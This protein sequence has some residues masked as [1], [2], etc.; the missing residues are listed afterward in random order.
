MAHISV[1]S[2]IFLQ[3]TQLTWFDSTTGRISAL[4]LTE[5]YIR[6]MEVVNPEQFMSLIEKHLGEPTTPQLTSLVLDQSLIFKKSIPTTASSADDIEAFLNIVPFE[7]VAQTQVSTQTETLVMATNQMIITCV[8]R[9]LRK[10]GD[11]LAV[12]LPQTVFDM[13]QQQL[14]PLTLESATLMLTQSPGLEAYNLTLPEHP[15]VVES[16]PTESSA[17]TTTIE[18]PSYAPDEPKKQST[19]KYLVPLF[20]LLVI[21]LVGLIVWQRQPPSRPTSTLV[22]AAT[23]NTTTATKNPQSQTMQI[24]A[25]QVS[26]QVLSPQT[27]LARAEEVTKTFSEAGFKMLPSS[28]Q[29]AIST[30]QTIVFVDSTYPKSLRDRIETLLKP[31]IHTFSIQ[32]ADRPANGVTIIIGSSE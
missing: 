18:R 15:K 13:S 4:P 16:K 22:K 28:Q 25:S 3:P 20:A 17:A 14:S 23:T 12:A 6:D 31:H 5:D 32:D 9:A 29:T 7:L 2:L 21:V 19:L 11:M 30:S 8:R 26:V 27:E 1:T 24:D 10:H